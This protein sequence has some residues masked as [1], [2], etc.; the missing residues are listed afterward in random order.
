VTD[1]HAIDPRS[2][3]RFWHDVGAEKWFAVDPKLDAEIRKRFGAEVEAASAGKRDR[4]LESVEG[5]LALLILLD[6]FPRNIYRGAAEAFASDARARD[7]A[8][9][10]LSRGYDLAVP[11]DMRAFFYLPYMHS[12]AM[13]DQ[14]LCVALIAQRLGTDSLNYP[15][16]LS[17][18]REIEQFGRFPGRNQALGRKTTQAEA[19]FLAE[20][21]RN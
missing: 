1:K 8:R 11:H 10:A 6:Q 18:R 12:E 4:W 7:V 15:F 14:D 17:H 16:A 13:A 5:T 21:S 3:V 9:H 20:R 2:I 19:A